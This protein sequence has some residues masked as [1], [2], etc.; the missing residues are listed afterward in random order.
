M[1]NPFTK[2]PQCKTYNAKIY[3]QDHKRRSARKK[4]ICKF[5]TFEDYLKGNQFN[6]KTHEQTSK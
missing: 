3:T 5:C 4:I 1:T 6:K 2:C